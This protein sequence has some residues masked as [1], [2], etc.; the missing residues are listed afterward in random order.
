MQ[1]PGLDGNGHGQAPQKEH[2]GVLQVFLTDLERWEKGE[3]RVTREGAFS[4]G[5]YSKGIS[6][7]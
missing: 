2:V 3:G 6:R 5:G 4:E 7:E 1:V